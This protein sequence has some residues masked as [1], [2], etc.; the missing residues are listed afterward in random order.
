MEKHIVSNRKLFCHH[1]T[2]WIIY[3]RKKNIKLEQV[4]E[5]RVTHMTQKNAEIYYKLHI[6]NY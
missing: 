6:T 2:E 5:T 4:N 3:S 1:K